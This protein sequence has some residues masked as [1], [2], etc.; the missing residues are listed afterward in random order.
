M[1]AQLKNYA[2]AVGV[3]AAA[4]LARLSLDI[5]TAQTLSFATFYPAVLLAALWGGLGPGILSVVLST[6][7][8]WYA[9]MAPRWEFKAPN[10]DTE[11]S[12]LLFAACA[13]LLVWIAVRY[14]TTLEQLHVEEERRELL[15][16]EMHH[17]SKNT[18]AVSQTIVNQT[19]KGERELAAKINGRLEALTAANDILVRSEDQTA[20][21]L[22]IIKR[23]VAA[24]GAERVHL[25]GPALRLGSQDTRSLA[26]I[27]HELATNAAKYGAFSHPAGRI[28]VSWT[29]EDPIL[30]LQW[31]ESGG[32]PVL[33]PQVTG[34]GSQLI[35]GITRAAGGSVET[36][37]AP[38]G[39]QCHITLKPDTEPAVTARTAPPAA[40]STAS[41]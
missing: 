24:Y 22:D 4:A 14:R 29:F 33:E 27:I 34:F 36:R 25:K 39:L 7:V 30:S 23:E 38:E 3:V 20:R 19:L 31:R 13:A 26:L 17:R 21:L 2:L 8:G 41:V 28:D 11:I 37:F 40:A 15:I 6:A 35:H 10:T 1:N 9:F 12:I 18:L 16:R 32:P 5:I